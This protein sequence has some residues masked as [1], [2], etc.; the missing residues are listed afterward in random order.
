[1]PARPA[2]RSGLPQSVSSR[3][4]LL[5]TLPPGL[6]GSGS[7]RTAT[8]WGTLKSASRARAK[9][10]DRLHVYALAGRRNDHRADLLAHHLVGNADD[11]DLADAWRPREHVLDFQRVDVLAPAV[12]HVLL[13]VDDVEQAVLVDVREVAGV[14][15]AVDE[16]LGRLLGLFQ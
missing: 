15:P 8:Y 12:D 7:S 9:S 16:R 3:S 2:Q 13:T 1:M 4:L 5:S 14:K 6:R 11:R 10:I